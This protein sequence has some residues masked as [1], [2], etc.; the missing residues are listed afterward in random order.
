VVGVAACATGMAFLVWARQTPGKNWSQ[1]VSA[2][3]GHEL[4]TSGAYRL[5]GHPMYAGGLLACLASAI[6]AGGPFVF[7]LLTLEVA[8]QLKFLRGQARVERTVADPDLKCPRVQA[9][10]WPSSRSLPACSGGQHSALSATCQSPGRVLSGARAGDWPRIAKRVQIE[11]EE[12][13]SWHVGSSARWV[14]RS[15]SQ[16]SE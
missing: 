5:A 12:P 14:A 6:V 8:Q 13:L 15:S 2:K 1:T 7:G 10:C 16:Y 11:R 4:V 9:E 3:Q